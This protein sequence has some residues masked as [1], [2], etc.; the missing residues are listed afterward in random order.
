[1]A[2]SRISVITATLNRRDLLRRAIESVI[3]QGLDDVEHIIIDGVSTDGTLEMLATYRHLIV[4]SEADN[5]LYQAWNKG[6]RRCSGNL[7][8]ILNSDDEI[9]AGAFAHA[10]AAL[11]AYPHLDM[12]SGAAEI[13]SIAADGRVVT[14]RIDD[15]RILSLREQDVG[16]GIPVINARY[17]TPGLVKRVGFLDERYRLNADRE[18]LFR[19]F[20]AR[21][22]NVQVSAPLYRYYQHAGSLTISDASR[23]HRYLALDNLITARQSLAEAI[24]PETRAVYARWHAWSAFYLAAFETRSGHFGSAISTIADAFRRDPAWPLRVP[25]QIFRHALEQAS[26][27]GHEV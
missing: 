18:Y 19:V 2:L 8:C 17:L 23:A 25:R 16:P 15:P 3:S 7:I 9:P 20:L 11:E 22:D 1:M 12:I 24:S 6:L 26:R 14:R 27:L 13:R 4:I 5:G 10:R 21:P